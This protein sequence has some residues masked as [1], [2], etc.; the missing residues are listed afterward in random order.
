MKVGGFIYGRNDADFL[1]HSLQSL[2]D[3]KLDITVYI[4]D[5][6]TDNSVEIA[7]KLGA[8][9][10]KL[11]FHQSWLGTPKLSIPA[12][13]GLDYMRDTDY[14]LVNGA[15]IILTAGY[16]N[17]LLSL[18]EENPKIVIISG[19]IAGERYN[20]NLPTGAGRLHNS[21]FWNRHIV[22]HPFSFIWESYCVYKAQSLGYKTVCTK[23]AIMKPLRPQR[24]GWHSPK[25]VLNQA[26]AMKQLGYFPPYAMLSAIR[27]GGIKAL[28]AYM[29]CNYDV[30]DQQLANYVRRQ[31]CHRLI[32]LQS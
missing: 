3:Q 14:F 28:T 16:V 29:R 30:V 7:E 18:M 22:K 20:K 11:P 21:K 9:V 12:N 1:K 5:G 31:N 26:Y 27:R 15:D 10:V 32:G 8:D 13:K 4:D 19:V 25:R 23:K 24:Q 2:I 17:T 6:S